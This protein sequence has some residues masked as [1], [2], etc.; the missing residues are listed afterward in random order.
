MSQMK[1]VCGFMMRDH[2]R[3]LEFEYECYKGSQYARICDELYEEGSTDY[4][5]PEPDVTIWR[6]PKC[7]RIYWFEGIT[8]I[9]QCYVPFEPSDKGNELSN[10][11]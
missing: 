5:L 1:C 3:P 8:N 2:D 11:R 9:A 10:T 7:Q 4:D 6:C